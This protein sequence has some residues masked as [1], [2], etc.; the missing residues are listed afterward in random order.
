MILFIIPIQYKDNFKQDIAV[1][2]KKRIEMYCK[3]DL[4]YQ[5]IDLLYFIWYF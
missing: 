3:V 4:H 1:P 2:F 5:S